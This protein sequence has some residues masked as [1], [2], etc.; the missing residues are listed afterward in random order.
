M[1][2][3]VEGHKVITTATW[4]GTHGVALII[5]TKWADKVTTA[6]QISHRLLEIR[7]RTPK[8]NIKWITAHAPHMGRPEEEKQGFYTQLKAMIAKHPQ[9]KLSLIHISEPTRLD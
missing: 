7:T 9:D 3:E 5:G 2:I 6:R 4:K 1:E 8:G